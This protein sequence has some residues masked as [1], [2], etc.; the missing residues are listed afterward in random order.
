MYYYYY[1]YLL[2]V[3][4]ADSRCTEGCALALASYRIW[5]SGDLVPKLSYIAEIFSN[6]SISEI[7]SYNPSILNAIGNLDG[8]YRVNV[9]F[10]C[11]CLNNGDYLGP[12]L[13][14]P[15]FLWVHL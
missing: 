6:I 12:R 2:S 3:D 1:Y 9:P 10:S 15:C 7:C 13:Y 4:Y 11:D 5:L 14:I 8:K